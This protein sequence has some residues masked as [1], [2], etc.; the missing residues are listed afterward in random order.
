MTVRPHPRRSLIGPALAVAA[1]V[2]AGACVSAPSEAVPSAATATQ[3]P[4]TTSTEAP[5][6]AGVAG[7]EATRAPGTADDPSPADVPAAA[8][9]TVLSK[10]VN[11]STNGA[12]FVPA[13]DGDMVQEGDTVQADDGRAVLTFPDGSTVE[14]EPKSALTIDTLQLTPDGGV[15]LS[16]TLILGRSWHV[17]APLAPSSSYEV[18]TDAS[19]AKVK[20]TEF[21]VD[22]DRSGDVPVATVATTEGTVATTAAG[23]ADAVLVT[24]GEVTTVKKGDA[25]PAPPKPKPEPARIATTTI[26]SSNGVVIDAFGRSNGFV[27]GRRVLQTPGAQARREG[28]RVVVT[29]PD[30]PDGVLTTD[31]GTKQKPTEPDKVKVETDVRDRSGAVHV[32]DQNVARTAGHDGQAGIEITRNTSGATVREL[33]PTEKAKLETPN[34][35]PIPEK[36]PVA[37]RGG[38]P[39]KPQD[40]PSKPQKQP[41][42][43]EKVTPAGRPS[44]PSDRGGPRDRKSKKF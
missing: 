1:L 21:E 16:V 2:V 10:T 32:V 6:L 35:H 20:G 4:E 30:P 36:R 17:V 40:K 23:S 27:N 29:I 26:D 11:V 15:V 7:P 31:V 41:A 38:D 19:V 37:P 44:G 25:R 42:V 12:A 14:I 9:V 24:K 28:G 13:H 43:P 39:I 5:L 18:K 3:A 34:I 8:R 33:R 22:V